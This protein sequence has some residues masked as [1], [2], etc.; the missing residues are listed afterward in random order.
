M[1]YSDGTEFVLDRA[2]SEVHSSWIPPSTPED[3]AT[4]FLGP[5]LG[6]VLYLRGVTCLHASAI[7][8]EGVALVFVGPA[9]AGKSTLAAAY[10]RRCYR[11]LTDDILVLVRNEHSIVAIP[12][13]PRI[14]L[15]PQSV[16]QLWGSGDALPKQVATW[17]KRYFDL[18]GHGLFQDAPLPVGAVYLLAERKPNVAP[19]I[20]PLMGTDA[21]LALIA[22]KYVTRY[23]ERDQDRR[24]F[25]LISELAESVPIRHLTC[26]DTLSD[27]NATCEAILA[28]YEALALTPA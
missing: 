14:G 16:K 21:L 15:W 4:Y 3:V 23:S 27:L 19:R 13:V 6:L 26:S 17:E 10:A 25:V 11:V 5:V 24:D 18:D 7:A 1:R 2:G 22:N 12:G 8:R 28:D 9:E 20:G